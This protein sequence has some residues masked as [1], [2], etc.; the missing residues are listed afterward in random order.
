MI[1]RTS[2]RPGANAA[3]RPDRPS[4]R[5]SDV[6][7]ERDRLTDKAESETLEAP[8]GAVGIQP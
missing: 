3:T 8:G 7:D 6:G 4:P 2:Q 1:E 5:R